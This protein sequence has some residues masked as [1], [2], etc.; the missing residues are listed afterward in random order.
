MSRREY[1]RRDRLQQVCW[2]TIYIAGA[3]SST[4]LEGSPR[5]GGS[6][7]QSTCLSGAGV[8]PSCRPRTRGRSVESAPVLDVGLVVAHAAGKGAELVHVD[9]VVDAYAPWLREASGE[10][11]SGRVPVRS[12]QWTP[13]LTPDVTGSDSWSVR[14]SRWY[15]SE[16][17]T[18]GKVPRRFGSGKAHVRGGSESKSEAKTQSGPLLGSLGSISEVSRKCLESD[19]GP[20]AGGPLLGRDGDVKPRV[21]GPP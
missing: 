17:S 1:T 11:L 3:P 13:N 14:S 20:D 2:R 15:G 18:C 5:A 16:S 21:N 10:G 12:A 7:T 9:P 19:R 4:F 6:H 8:S